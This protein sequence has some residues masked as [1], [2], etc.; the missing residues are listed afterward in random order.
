MKVAH[1]KALRRVTCCFTAQGRLSS[2]KRGRAVR[3]C[4]IATRN[5]SSSA[6]LEEATDRL[7]RGE[8][9]FLEIGVALS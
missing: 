3:A 4:T 5:S 6:S 2:T 7:I 9:E 1:L 8:C